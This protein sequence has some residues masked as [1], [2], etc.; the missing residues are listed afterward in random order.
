MAK[1]IA[2]TLLVVLAVLVLSATP[3]FAHHEPAHYPPGCNKP[4][5]QS[6]PGGPNEGEPAPGCVKHQEPA[7]VTGLP[8]A[9]IGD[10]SGGITVGMLS[11]AGL[12]AFAVW[13]LVRQRRR[14]Q[15]LRG[16]GGS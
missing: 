6:L 3:V 14:F 9:G 4:P 7:S 16:A 11:V 13:Y 5:A 12:G 10:E 1:K 2:P 15:A 8:T